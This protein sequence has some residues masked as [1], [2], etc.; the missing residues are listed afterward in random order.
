[1]SIMSKYAR[2]NQGI[3]DH[4]V[5]AGYVGALE[6]ERAAKAVGPNLTRQ[7]LMAQ[8]DNG[9]VYTTDASLDQ[10]FPLHPRGAVR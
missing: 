10:R 9:G 3:N 2:G 4:V 7:R 5:Q 8:L 1:M 6:F